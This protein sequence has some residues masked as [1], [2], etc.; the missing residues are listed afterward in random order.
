MQRTAW[1]ILGHSEFALKNYAE[2]EHAYRESLQRISNKDKEYQGIY[3][4]LAASIYKQ[5]EKERDAG[6][7]AAAVGHFLRVG[8]VTPA[9]SLRAT[10]DFDAATGL[11]NLKQYNRASSLLE[12]FR[13]RYP[14]NPLNASIPEKLALIYSETGQSGRA[15]HE[16]EI[17]ARNN[18]AN[19]KYSADLLW[20]AGT[21]YEKAKMDKDAQ[22]V[23]TQ[24]VRE[25]PLPLE[26]AEEGRNKLAEYARR[27]GDSRA[28]GKM[29][30]EI[31][32]AD[33]R[34]GAQR[35][36]RTRFLAADATLKLAQGQEVQYKRVRLTQPIKRSLKRKKVLLQA[37]IKAYETAIAYRV[38]EVTT[39]ATYQLGE[40]YADF[41]RSLSKSER[42]RGLSGDALAQYNVMLDDQAFPFEEKSI[43]IH[44]TNVHEISEGIYDKWVKASLAKLRKV[45]PARYA[46]DEKVLPYVESI[47]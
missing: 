37:T 31:I 30:Q 7:L 25:N 24:Y 43:D 15:A 11:I 17:L 41:A 2:A 38:A 18:R 28:W 34:G 39:S 1:I 16:M 33:A 40:L 29:L 9:S 3:D 35:T 5:G 6:N 42:P 45:D 10:A 32:R 47:Y 23:F 4:R 12:A 14:K 8:Q 20:Q 36:D 46:K 21:Y 26:R 44:V 27:S 13:H 22:R 19:K